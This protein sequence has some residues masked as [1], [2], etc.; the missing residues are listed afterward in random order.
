MVRIFMTP[1]FFLILSVSVCGQEDLAHC[2]KLFENFGEAKVPKSCSEALIKEASGNNHKIKETKEIFAT[3]NALFI[4]EGD[5]LSIQAGRNAQ[6][7]G[8]VAIDLSDDNLAALKKNGDIHLYH[9][10]VLG[11]V[12]PMKILTNPRFYGAL[13]ISLG[14][15]YLAILNPKENSLLFVEPTLK[16]NPS[17][18]HTDFPIAKEVKL[19]IKEAKSISYNKTTHCFELISESDQNIPI[20]L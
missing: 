6:V 9:P 13:D 17:L 1:F 15:N 4:K 3:E 8:T 10:Q 20:C 14:Q 11:N 19:P 2:K 16:V 18:D 12:A 5:K 7:L